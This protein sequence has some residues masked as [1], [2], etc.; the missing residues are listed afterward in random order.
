MNK[1]VEKLVED[2]RISAEEAQAYRTEDDGA[3]VLNRIQKRFERDKEI[4]GS[5]FEEGDLDSAVDAFSM[6]GLMS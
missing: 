4:L 2:G 3:D 5:V 1:M 6:L